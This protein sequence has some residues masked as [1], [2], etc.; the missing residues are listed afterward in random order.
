M[1]LQNSP[2]NVLYARIAWNDERIDTAWGNTSVDS[3]DKSCEDPVT[4]HVTT[5]IIVALAAAITAAATIPKCNEKC[6]S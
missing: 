1:Y 4:V 5:T 6:Q 3:C 2:M